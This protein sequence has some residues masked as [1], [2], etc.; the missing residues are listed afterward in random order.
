ML[1][2]YRFQTKNEAN[3]PLA[4]AICPGANPHDGVSDTVSQKQYH[5]HT[6]RRR[7]R[8]PSSA[9]ASPGKKTGRTRPSGCKEPAILSVSFALAIHRAAPRSRMNEA[10]VRLRGDHAQEEHHREDTDRFDDTHG[11]DH[12]GE[13]FPFSVAERSDSSRADHALHPG[14]KHFRHARS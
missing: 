5:Y 3:R 1:S 14:R 9:R 6:Q 10:G 12:E 4:T 2:R 13:H 8:Q 7:V 11:D